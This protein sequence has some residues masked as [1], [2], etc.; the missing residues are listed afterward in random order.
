MECNIEELQDGGK[1]ELARRI[2]QTNGIAIV[3]VGSLACVRSLYFVA[4]ELGR[5][6]FLFIR[7][8]T[9]RDYALGNNENVIC[10]LIEEASSHSYVKGVIIYASCL[11]ILSKWDEE[12]LLSRVNNPNHIPVEILYRGPLAKRKGSSM[13]SLNKIL[14][15]WNMR[16]TKSPDLN[17]SF[18]THIYEAAVPEVSDFEQVIDQLSKEECDVLLLTP[19]GCKSCLSCQN[20]KEYF[21]IKNTRFTD[22]FLSVM[23]PEELA[24]EIIRKIPGERPLYLLGTAVIKMIGL[25]VESLIEYLKYRKKEVTYINSDGFLKL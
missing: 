17:D 13:E 9:A 7:A 12:E 24:E 6:N 3:A 4:K 11:D 18:Y 15:G 23:Q 1:M 10:R 2:F 19:G 14:D 5:T 21:N 16:Q 22:R 25:D 8:L 20:N